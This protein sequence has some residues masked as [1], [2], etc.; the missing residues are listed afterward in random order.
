MHATQV[1]SFNSPTSIVHLHQVRGATVNNT[2]DCKTLALPDTIR[3]SKPPRAVL[4]II[5]I[6]TDLVMDTEGSLLVAQLPGVE[7]RHAK[8]AFEEEEICAATYDQAYEQGA[9]HAAV[10]TL[11]W[12][13]RNL[14]GGE[15]ITVWGMSCTSISFILGPD[16][17]KSCFPDGA[18]TTDMWTSVLKALRCLE[19]TKLAVLTPYQAEVSS[20]NEQLL[21]DEGFDV[22]A[23]MS[24]GLTRDV[25]TSAVAP[26]FIEEC[27]TK[28]AAESSADALFIGC[29][30]FR[31]CTPGFITDLEAKLGIP[32]V[33][34]TQAFLWHVLR[35]AL[36][37]DSLD[38]YGKLFREH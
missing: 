28:L 1:A 3:F 16:K 34:S 23:T 38:G 17:V 18:T 11:Q 4:G 15:Y 30:A 9:I 21:K 2:P 26:D 6:A 14:Q 20:K 29:S 36:V 13:E 37:E 31:A 10:N 8:I 22:V 5:Q 12:P 27:A 35:T 25:E 24:L 33:T 32:V 7:I 19:A